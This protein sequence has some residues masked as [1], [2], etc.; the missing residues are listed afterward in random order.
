MALPQE[1]VLR[2]KLAALFAVL[3]LAA[4]GASAQL[5]IGVSGA[6][7]MDSKLDAESISAAFKEGSAILYGGFAELGMGHIGLGASVNSNAYTDDFTANKMR[8]IDADVYLSYHLF[9][10]KAFLD[11]F[12]EFG[13]GLMGLAYDGFDYSLISSW[14]GASYYWYGALGL[15]IN[16]DSVGVFGKFAYNYGIDQAVTFNDEYGIPTD[17]ETSYYIDAFRF[18]LGVKLIL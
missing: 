18:T 6:L 16:L 17:L 10:A 15:G 5:M 8:T 7:P 12:G 11:P 9:K 2:K 1:D 4:A 3:A 13:V 14:V